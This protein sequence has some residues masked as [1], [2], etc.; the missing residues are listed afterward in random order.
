MQVRR[1]QLRAGRARSSGSAGLGDS[2]LATA[3]KHAADR[4]CLSSE[5]GVTSEPIG[6]RQSALRL[7]IRY[8]GADEWCAL[9]GTYHLH[10]P[11]DL[12]TVHDPLVNQLAPHGQQRVVG[13]VPH[14][15]A[16]TQPANSRATDPRHGLRH[17]RADHCGLRSRTD[18]FPA[19]RRSVRVRP[20]DGRLASCGN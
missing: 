16:Y 3:W 8:D 19:P 1:Q 17:E 5:S 2:N 20:T 15:T 18:E 13:S 14:H 10:T 6:S 11:E 9:R 4:T 12:Q 7:A